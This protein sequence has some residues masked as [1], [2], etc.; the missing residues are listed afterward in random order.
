M[1]GKPKTAFSVATAGGAYI[2]TAITEA[3]AKSWVPPH[4]AIIR[5]PFIAAI[6]TGAS[7]AGI[8]EGGT[9]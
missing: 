7:S 9:C 1:T 4:H 8:H 2:M 5:R 6:A 3:E